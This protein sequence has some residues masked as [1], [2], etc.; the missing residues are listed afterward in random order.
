MAE[1]RLASRGESPSVK[2]T[3]A[4]GRSDSRRWLRERLRPSWTMMT[5][6]QIKA[7]AMAGKRVEIFMAVVDG[8]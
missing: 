3:A 8:G 4:S 7:A 1:G 6:P 2:A 5:A